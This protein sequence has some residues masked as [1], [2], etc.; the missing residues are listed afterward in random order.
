[1]GLGSLVRRQ[2]GRFG[3]C[4]GMGKAPRQ[5]G[6]FGPVIILSLYK[7]AHS[8][9]TVDKWDNASIR[10]PRRNAMLAPRKIAIGTFDPHQKRSSEGHVFI[11]HK[12]GTDYD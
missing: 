2:T 10:V 3:G 1:L 12:G 8:E 6:H 7:I 9:L 11:Q 5:I 4:R